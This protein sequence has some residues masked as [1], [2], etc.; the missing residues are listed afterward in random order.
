[1]RVGPT[2]SGRFWQP[3]IS[4]RSL[5]RRPGIR[6]R[7]RPSRG[8]GAGRSAASDDRQPIASQRSHGHF[9]TGV[10]P[11]YLRRADCADQSRALAPRR[12]DNNCGGDQ[13]IMRSDANRDARSQRRPRRQRPSHC[14]CPGQ[15]CRRESDAGDGL[16]DLY[17]RDASISAIHGDQRP[18]QPHRRRIRARRSSVHRREGRHHQGIRQPLGYDRHRLRG[19]S[20]QRLQLPR[21]RF[22]RHGVASRLPKHAVQSMSSTRTMPTSAAR[23]QSGARRTRRPIRVRHRQARPPTAVSSAPDCRA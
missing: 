15:G 23:R 8:C 14:R 9:D 18:H 20:D 17:H 16:M 3:S 19:S 13:D 6:C 11:D 4:G 21:P 5:P 22:A 1:M 2:I 12:D 7:R 10:S